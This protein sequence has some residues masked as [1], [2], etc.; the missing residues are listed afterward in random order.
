M[1]MGKVCYDCLEVKPVFINPE[2]QQLIC[3]DCFRK[4]HKRGGRARFSQKNKPDR[5][6]TMSDL[7][8]KWNK[9]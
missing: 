9:K 6:P 3:H 5:D 1:P 7:M 8:H 2:T 4:K